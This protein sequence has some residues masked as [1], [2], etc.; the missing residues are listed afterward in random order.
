M[1]TLLAIDTASD[2]CSVALCVGSETHAEFQLAPRRHGELIL[3][4]IEAI[5]AQAQC[6]LAQLDAIAFGRGPGSF[7]GVRIAAGVV[8]GV[9]MGADLPVIPVSNLAALAQGAV[10]KTSLNS[11]AV[12]IDARMGEVYFGCYTLASSGCV[13]LVGRELVVAPNLVELPDQ[14]PCYG[15]GSG[16]QSYAEPLAT[17]L[18]GSVTQW[19]AQALPDARHMIVLAQQAWRQNDWV[20]PEQAL[21]VYLRDKVAKL[22]KEK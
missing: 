12:A 7:T 9:A 5:L 4:M 15:V 18:H 11:F 22:P 8:Q 2:A 16:W 10:T 20:T 17:R 14:T 6:S 13:S 3:P 19:D 21:P 1:T